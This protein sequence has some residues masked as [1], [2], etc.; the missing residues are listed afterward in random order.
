MLGK[1]SRYSNRLQPKNSGLHL[2]LSELGSFKKKVGFKPLI[3]KSFAFFCLTCAW[4]SFLSCGLSN[5][6]KGSCKPGAWV[7]VGELVAGEEGVF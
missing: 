1:V 6:H 4:T 3:P 7:G 2:F 5:R